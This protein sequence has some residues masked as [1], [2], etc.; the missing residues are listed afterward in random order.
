MSIYV[1]SRASIPERGAMWRH[2]RSRGVPIISSWIDEDG[3]GET[4]DF[5]LLWM[6]IE[7]EIAES[8]H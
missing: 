6:R 3:E 1:A 5:T 8:A 4:S 2:Y 7:S